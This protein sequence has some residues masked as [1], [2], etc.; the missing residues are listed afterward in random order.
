MGIVQTTFLA[1]GLAVDA[2]AVSLTSGL[3]IKYISLN[4]AIKIALC[5]GIFQALMPLL[6]WFSGLIFQDYLTAV[7][8]WI[9]F[10]L[11]SAIG[12]KMIYESVTADEDKKFN[13]LDIF[14]LIGLAIATSIDALAAGFGLS[15][16]KHTILSTAGSLGIITFI[17]SFSSVY[18]GHFCGDL[19]KSKVEV[20]GGLIIIAIGT[21]VLFEHLLF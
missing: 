17:C 9:V 8:H 19:F 14:T 16:I 13:P 11:L 21:K 18:L 7:D 6:G 1:I 10:I 15:T 5:F 3:I 20:M 4:K 12:S 2:C